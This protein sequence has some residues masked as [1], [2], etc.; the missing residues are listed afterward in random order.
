M[1]LVGLLQ[2]AGKVSAIARQDSR[3]IL[4]NTPQSTWL[5]YATWSEV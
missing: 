4:A 3:L 5:E 2:W 1:E